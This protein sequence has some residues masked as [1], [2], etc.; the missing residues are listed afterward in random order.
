[1]VRV[2][3]WECD[4]CGAS[5]DDAGAGYVLWD[6]RDG[7]PEGYRIIHRGQCDDKSYRSSMPLDSFL[8]PDG[9]NSLLGFLSIG[10]IK[11]ALGE[12]GKPAVRDMDAFVDFVRR[13]QIPGY[14]QVRQHF[15]DPDI[16]DRFADATE[17][18]PYRLEV[19]DDVL[20]L[21]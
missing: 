10:P 17:T 1:M 15:G 3:P 20:S 5:I 11:R 8:G 21:R 14:E 9:L 12:A 16:L 6:R 2:G 4:Q 18:Y 7:G 19:I 13:V